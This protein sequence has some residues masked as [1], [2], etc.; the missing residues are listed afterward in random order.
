MALEIAMA[1][2]EG[3]GKFKFHPR[4]WRESDVWGKVFQ[5][6]RSALTAVRQT[7]AIYNPSCWGRGSFPFSCRLLV[8]EIEVEGR[9][10][11]LKGS[12]GALAAVVQKTKLG[13]SFGVPSFGDL[14]LPGQDS[15]LQP[16]G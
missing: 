1:I 8:G 5:E 6:S 4:R 15:N 14:W 12:Y 9:E 2:A 16:T 11:Q 13:H 10:V 3:Q 7:F